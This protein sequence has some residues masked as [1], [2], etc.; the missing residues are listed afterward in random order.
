MVEGEK[1]G[2]LGQ[3]LGFYLRSENKSKISFMTSVC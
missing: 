1:E 3:E 2:K